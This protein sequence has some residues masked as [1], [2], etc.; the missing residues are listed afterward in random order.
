M[1]G[2]GCIGKNNLLVNQ[3]YGPRIRLRAI[4]L[5]AALPSIRAVEF[6]LIFKRLQSYLKP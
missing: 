6:N 1:A 3:I 4:L 5:D 2:L